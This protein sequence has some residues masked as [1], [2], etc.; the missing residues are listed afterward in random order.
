MVGV[1]N[2]S[3]ERIGW[4]FR[5]HYVCMRYNYITMCLIIIGFPIFISILSGSAEPA[6][7]SFNSLTVFAFV[8]SFYVTMLSVRDE[9]RYIVESTLPLSHLER[10]LFILLNTTIVLA[11]IFALCYV[12]ALL[13]STSIYPL[14]MEFGWVVGDTFCMPEAYLGLLSTHAWILLANLT[15]RKRVLYNYIAM[16][17]IIAVGQ[18]IISRYV[19]EVYRADVRV[20]TNIL[21]TLVAWISGYF[22]LRRREIKM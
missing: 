16:L 18:F 15:A 14:D 17:A 8:D 6:I 13:I 5:R 3:I 20:W 19:P 22:I 7:T 4:M 11:V 9:R 2:F 10:Y 1:Q 12:L 21:V